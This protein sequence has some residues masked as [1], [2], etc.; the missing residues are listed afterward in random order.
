M[1]QIDF[2]VAIWRGKWLLLLALVLGA[3]GALAAYMF[4]PSM[5]RS[6]AV[7]RV[8]SSVSV[9]DVQEQQPTIRAESLVDLVNQRE[10]Q[11]EVV[12]KTKAGLPRY[13]G[14]IITAEIT[15][16]TGLL[17]VHANARSAK[18]SKAWADAAVKILLEKMSSLAGDDPTR[19]R[20]TE[21]L[22]DP[23]IAE[24]EKLT[25]SMETA[26][27][28]SGAPSIDNSQSL[29]RINDLLARLRA[30]Q[31]D[32]AQTNI[33]TLDALADEI[34]DLAATPGTADEVTVGDRTEV[35]NLSRRIQ[36]LEK[37]YSAYW[38][39]MIQMRLRDTVTG[40]FL[41]VVSQP[42]V[43]AARYTGNL[44]TN[45]AI[46]ALMGLLVGLLVAILDEG[47]RRTGLEHAEE[48]DKE[49]YGARGSKASGGFGI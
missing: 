3:V 2:V 41:V 45:S 21:Q 46:G 35:A 23:T 1:K 49:D 15:S 20:I 18:Q 27:T 28:R 6:T 9:G 40:D 37:A 38:D 13:S 16:G 48:D 29:S 4:S 10:F 25:V 43:P 34:D 14:N 42:Q 24:I 47:R 44:L 39:Y 22:L 19:S 30:V 5:Y 8:Q 17:R 33:Q 32:G 11:Q 36:N 7:L 12:G 31:P 26:R